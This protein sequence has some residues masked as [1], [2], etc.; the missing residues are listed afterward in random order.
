M[1]LTVT[2]GLVFVVLTNQLKR[3]SGKKAKKHEKNA[4]KNEKIIRKVV[5]LWCL[6]CSG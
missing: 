3:K 4:N 5:K 6:V 2:S 1:M